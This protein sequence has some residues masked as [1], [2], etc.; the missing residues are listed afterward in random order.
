MNSLLTLAGI[1]DAQLTATSA[2]RLKRDGLIA[3]ARCILTVRDTEGA[4]LAAIALRDVKTFTRSIEEARADV[5]GP[6]LDLGK[7]IDALARELTAELET[8]AT[9]LSRVLGA[10][11]AEEKR[12]ADEAREKALA[13]ERRIWEEAKA[14]EEAIV[15]EARKKEAEEREKARK[16]AE[17]LAAKASRARSE[18]GRAKALEEAENAKM[19]AQMEA[20]ER[21]RAA[22]VE[23]QDRIEKARISMV[24]AR[25]EAVNV[26]TPKPAGVS[27]RESYEFEVLDIAQLY[28]AHPLFVVLTPNMTVIKAA[29]KQ[30]PE[31]KIIPGIRFWK[32]SKTFVR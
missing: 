24:A 2:A 5:K 6:V 31:G 15:A 18:A 28:E 30:L 25:V 7:R 11:Q 17:E 13:E 10:F 3:D 29:L 27:T 21:E 4:N 32:S 22:E 20:D 1:D 16:E 14:K 26:V 23:R 19:R 9:R 8:E 12:K